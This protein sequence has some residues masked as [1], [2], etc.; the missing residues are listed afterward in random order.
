[1]TVRQVV[2]WAHSDEKRVAGHCEMVG[3]H[4]VDDDRL[5]GEEGGGRRQNP[6]IPQNQT[7]PRIIPGG[8]RWPLDGP[9]IR[10]KAKDAGFSAAYMMITWYFVWLGGHRRA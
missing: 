7:R 6:Q 2:I 5:I 1:M 3:V 10:L 4:A 8:I 9:D